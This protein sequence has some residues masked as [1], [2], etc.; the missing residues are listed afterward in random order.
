MSLLYFIGFSYIPLPGQFS[1][2]CF[3]F[4]KRTNDTFRL[5]HFRKCCE[6]VSIRIVHFKRKCYEC[7]EFFVHS[8]FIF[9]FFFFYC[10]YKAFILNCG[11][12]NPFSLMSFPSVYHND[13]CSFGESQRSQ[14]NK[15]IMPPD[16]EKYFAHK[17]LHPST[18]LLKF[19]HAVIPQIIFRS[20]SK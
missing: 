10:N 2:C 8:F 12:D 17:T 14:A 18:S 9:F 4:K 1:G 3:R 5:I 16:M 20:A 6:N 13:P 7:F 19:H 11:N 15:G